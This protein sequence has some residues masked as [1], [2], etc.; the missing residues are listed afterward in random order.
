MTGKKKP[1]EAPKNLIPDVR[2]PASRIAALESEL[3]NLELWRQNKWTDEND[4]QKRKEELEKLLK[5]WRSQI[6]EK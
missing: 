3:F 2:S 6:V 4:Y 1:D 5:Y